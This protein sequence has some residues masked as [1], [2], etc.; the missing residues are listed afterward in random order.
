MTEFPKPDLDGWSHKARLLARLARKRLDSAVSR[1]GAVGRGNRPA[2]SIWTQY[3]P[4]LDWLPKYNR[5]RDLPG[6]S[7][8]GAVVAIML[9]PQSMAYALLAGLPPQVGLYAAILP[10]LLYAVFGSSRALAVG[11][12]AIVSLMV[13]SSLGDMGLAQGT[14]EYLTAA[15]AL[16]LLSGLILTGAGLLRLGFLTNFISH[17]VIAGFT[18]AAALIIGF[19][20]LKSLLGIKLDRSHFIPEIIAQAAEKAH[21]VNPLTLM[22][23][24][25]AI[26][27]LL[28]QNLLAEKLKDAGVP[29]A[30]AQVLPKGTALVL[31]ILG[32]LFVWAFGLDK[33]FGVSI[34]GTIPAGLPPVTAPEVN[35]TLWRE[36]LP[37]AILISVVG[38]VESLSVAKS[39]ASKKRQRISAN[40]ELIGLGSANLGA[41]VTGGYAV[42]GGFSRS[43]VNFKAGANTQL[44]AIITAILIA[45]TLVLFAPLLYFLPKAILA[46]I[47]VVAVAT[48]VDFKPFTHAWRYNK[49]DGIAFAATFMAV[50]VLGVELGIL[51]GIVLSIGM[52]LWK[53]SQPHIAIMGRVGETEIYRNIERHTVTTYDDLLIVRIDENLYFANTAYLEHRLLQ[54]V[55]SRPNVKALV[56]VMN[57]VSYVDISALDV[58]EELVER[59]REIGVT[60]HLAELKGPVMDMLVSTRLVG[61]LPPG[62]IFMTVHDAVEAV[63]RG[64]DEVS[65]ATT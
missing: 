23:S 47:I 39:L 37:A 11:P 15:L 32:V 21:L 36:L 34:V 7:M 24:I 19:S 46:A 59:L 2:Q 51:T 22:I 28:S 38:Y 9:I 13:A 45:I 58:I 26:A 49:P 48:L 6:D 8:A 14:P 27:T 44:S 60:V 40:Q 57:A 43:V 20:Q 3:L 10:L 50:L 1:F 31:V 53:T 61:H 55:S 62:R 16:A 63:R 25:V 35:W 52:Y 29:E 64:K 5:S 12:V 56:L 33:N 65:R 42:T 18:S 30:T 54:E 4:I 41:A 17:P